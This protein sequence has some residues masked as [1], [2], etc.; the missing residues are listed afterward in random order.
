MAQVIKRPRCK[1]LSYA[2]LFALNKHISSKI[3]S[4]YIFQNC[5]LFGFGII[6][7]ILKYTLIS[8]SNNSN[9]IHF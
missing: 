3:F 2:A 1:P 9:N 8:V 5:L 4:S 6:L 7:T